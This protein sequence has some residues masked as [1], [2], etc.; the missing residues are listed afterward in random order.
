MTD[1]AELGRS[2]LHKQLGTVFCAEREYRMTDEFKTYFNANFEFA[3]PFRSNTYAV[4]PVGS[5]K[6]VKPLEIFQKYST[7]RA[8]TGKVADVT[9]EEIEKHIK[10]LT[11]VDNK[12]ERKPCRT[13]ITEWLESHKD[14]WKFNNAWSCITYVYNG[15]PKNKTLDDL[16]DALM[17]TIY[18]EQLDYGVEEVKTSLSCIARDKDGSATQIVFDKIA[19]DA[20]MVDPCDRFLLGLYNYFKPE[21]SFDIWKT[22][23]KH[24][25][26][27]CKRRMLGR[28]VVW[29][30]WINLYGATGI[31]K[32]TIL[33]KLCAPMIDYTTVTNISTLFESTKEIAKLA[34]YYVMIFD[35]L[36]VNTEGE[37]GG[38][39]TEDNKATLKSILTA[40]Y[41]DVRVYGTQ[42][43]TKQKITF[44]PVSTANHH[45]Y[46]VIFDETS[47]RRFFEFHCTAVK[48]ESFDEINKYLEHVDVFWRGI[49]ENLDRGYWEPMG[50]KIGDEITKIQQSYYPTKTTT[51]MWIEAQKVTVGKRPGTH[52][53]KAY[54]AWCRETGNRSKTMQN[55]IKDIAHMIPLAIDSAGRA[56]LE[57]N[58]E[59]EGQVWENQQTI[60]NM[61]P[62][63]LENL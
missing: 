27:I 50:T 49:D 31:G 18:Q 6:Y 33:K 45:L 3:K 53:Y 24:W 19:Y 25:G 16:K 32:T 14:N 30:I 36:A 55:F 58:V 10:A 35:E 5:N 37:P 56:H 21:E 44:A 12:E 2:F 29:H 40:D 43:Q 4:R 63:P 26:W 23:W 46:D 52:A 47:M 54:T 48:P 42:R 13:W 39:L 8:S 9:V 57:Y 60:S 41:L 17:E 51:S 62:D 34:G 15:I 22:L 11:P 61:V 20:S 59:D 7:Y 28:D 38:N 1:G